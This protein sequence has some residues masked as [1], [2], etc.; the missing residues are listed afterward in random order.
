MKRLFIFLT[1]VF[2]M[3]Q[4]LQTFAQSGSLYDKLPSTNV[5]C[6]L[7]DDA[8]LMWIG[9][10]RGLSIFNGTGYI[11]FFT[12]GDEH[13]IPNDYINSMCKDPQG[14]I[15]IGTNLGIT[16]SEQ[17]Q[18]KHPLN[19]YFD[20]VFVVHDLDE[21]HI[22]SLYNDRLAKVDK[23]T[24]EESSCYLS[25]GLSPSSVVCVS[26]SGLI[27][28]VESLP[29][30][31]CS[32][33]ILDS[34]LHLVNRI[35]NPIGGRTITGGGDC[36]GQM[37]W[38][39]SDRDVICYDVRTMSQ[40]SCPTL[41][42]RVEGHEISFVT[43]YDENAIL[44]GLT[45]DGLYLYEW[46]TDKV[47]KIS[48]EEHLDGSSYKC[49]VDSQLNIWLSDE[50]FGFRC[51]PQWR[52]LVTMSSFMSEL[53][54]RSI[55]GF[56]ADPE[57]YFWVLTRQ[58]L[59]SIDPTFK[60]IKVINRSE[61]ES[62]A[63]LYLD[64]RGTLWMVEKGGVAL[65]YNLERGRAVLKEKYS[66]DSNI[67]AISENNES[68]VWILMGHEIVI[69]SDDGTN[70]HIP[71]PE[72]ITPVNLKN[73]DGEEVFLFASNGIYRFARDGQ[74][75]PFLMEGITCPSCITKSQDGTYWIGTNNMG[76]V[77]YDP[78]TNDR[79]VYN[80]ESGLSDNTVQSVITT[81]DGD[82]WFSTLLG[83][84]HYD[85]QDK[86]LSRYVVD[87]LSDLPYYLMGCAA[88]GRD[89]Q[90]L[91]ANSQGVTAVY[92]NLVGRLPE[93]R[94]SLFMLIV[95]NQYLNPE[96]KLKL[97][98]NQNNITFWLNSVDFD[99]FSEISY[100]YW[101]DGYDNGWQPS[102]SSER[103]T[104]SNLS[105]GRYTLHAQVLNPD[106]RWSNDD[107]SYSFVIR[108]KL[109]MSPLALIFY[110]L[111]ALFFIVFVANLIINYLS[112]KEQVSIMQQKQTMDKQHLDFL[113]NI[114]H[115][116]RTPL[117]LIYAPVQELRREQAD[118][119][120]GTELLDI[121]Q[122]NVDRLRTLTEQL[123]DF[124][125]SER[126]ESSLKVSYYNLTYFIK[127]IVDNFR[128]F[129]INKNITLTTTVPDKTE[130]W[131]DFEKVQKILS[132]L[133][134]NALKYTP[135]GG[136]VHVEVVSLPS[137]GRVSIHVVD[138]GI[139]IPED[140]RDTLF[141]RFDRLGVDEAKPEIVGNGIGL[142]YA[143][144]QAHVHKG[145]I[146]Y[147]PSEP[148][149]SDFCLTIPI[150]K[151]A[152]D[153][154][155]ITST[156]VIVPA[157]HL[158][159][160]DESDAEQKEQTVLIAEDN[161]EIA[162][163]LEGLFSEKWNV[164]TVHDGAE[165]LDN[166]QQFVPDL[167]I[168]D[169]VMPIKDGFALC[170]ELKSDERLAHVPIIL[171]TAKDDT[172]SSIMGLSKGADAYITKPFDPYY[173]L[174][175]ASTLVLNRRR[176]QSTVLNLTS[177]SLQDMPEEEQEMDLNPEDRKF[178]DDLHAAM[179]A[180]LSEESFN[181]NA[182]SKEL[183]MSYNNLYTRIKT[184]TGQTPQ[185][186]LNTYKMNVAME[187]LKSGKYNVSEVSYKVGAST[188]SNFSRSFK[189]QFGIPPSAVKAE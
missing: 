74:F 15:W 189:K 5:N 173:L 137:E 88:S 144:W 70:Q 160:T 48:P 164:I 130:G 162:S 181:V 100:R 109:L 39:N 171:L 81:L 142:N 153:D 116:L 151:S 156:N 82:V 72:S 139:G 85:V 27:W 47:E 108:P 80:S 71:I 78:S 157:P 66:F 77:H 42:Q 26:S 112:K 90:L 89:G 7:E 117:T 96:P 53:T 17:G 34:D 169:V 19:Y 33:L 132:N 75:S 147:H 16:V 125:T 79:V 11:N 113:T 43:P 35:D 29:G 146:T 168:S 120:K 61:S 101:L 148:A 10:G 87:R 180:N 24:F 40:R 161:I 12:A 8:G 183:E 1:G 188:L 129:A 111:L 6:F 105:P 170:E 182:L 21:N 46:S 64:T 123:L 65:N 124:E 121:V 154:S 114:S 185:V 127:M 138:D 41:S 14:R 59:V 186:Y 86:Y 131:F 60:E 174:A 118:D 135:E 128:F 28:T 163:Y 98:Y 31:G 95:D 99:V 91:F 119:P 177:S 94:V 2:L 93:R 141:A 54:S 97:K 136:N 4:S 83:I 45:G 51:L 187:L 76:L 115:E 104:Y 37:M 134:S 155:E 175:E 52:P 32:I 102:A 110:Y 152:Y 92:P 56:N 3:T 172:R 106:G 38:F 9:T 158:R 73:C 20:P 57:G 58:E 30:G 107:V 145:A 184:L 179:D 178:L 167:V 126:E 159:K 69:I 36:N 68:G 62:F 122:H 18:F 143:Q 63:S 103:V 149:G 140:K 84:G 133:L 166:V 22:L 67:L 150:V 23:D 49:F 44:V 176:M 55:I 165:A 13:S 25:T 50:K